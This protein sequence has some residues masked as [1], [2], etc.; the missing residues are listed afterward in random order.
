MN[1]AQNPLSYIESGRGDSI[2]LLDWTPWRTT[3]LADALAAQYRVLSIEPP[4]VGRPDAT[5]NPPAA[6]AAVADAAGLQSCTLIGT[7]AGADAAFR[8][9]L[10]R[11]NAINALILVSPTCVGASPHRP[12]DARAPA[13]DAML[14]HPEN[15][16]GAPSDT[17]AAALAAM[18]QLWP[19]ASGN[20]DATS[21]LSQLQCPTLAVFGQ[22][23]RIV[24]REAA[25]LWRELAP[26]CNICFVYDGGHAVGIDRPDAL[27]AVVSDFVRRRETFI[28]E[29]RSSVINP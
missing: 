19:T 23:D 12:A 18:A 4:D 20:D 10:L 22:E 21:L 7:S 11:P 15:A 25:R 5:Q 27:I 14:A 3:A 28:V 26:N 6:V 9:A 29:N 1:T 2:L 24:P 8:L 17:R 13:A 16:P